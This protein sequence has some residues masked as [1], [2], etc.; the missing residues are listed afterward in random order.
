MVLKDKKRWIGFSFA[1]NGLIEAVKSERNFQYHI[2]TAFIV[3][4]FGIFFQISRLE[5]GIIILVI[6]LL[7]LS[8]MINSTVEKLIDYLKPDIHPTAKIITDIAAGSILIS[9]IIAV[10]I[11]LIVFIPKLNAFL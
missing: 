3:I 11:R 9:A 6:V 2:V 7:L 10:I 5:W 4:V 1:W 8:E